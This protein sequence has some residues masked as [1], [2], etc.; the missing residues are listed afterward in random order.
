MIESVEI[1]QPY[2]SNAI[3]LVLS[4]AFIL[5]PII[6]LI[7]AWEVW[8]R[9]INELFIKNIE[10]SQLE[11]RIPKDVFKSPAAM[12]L[13][14]HS[15]Y[16]TSGVNTWVKKY[17]LG[18]LIYWHS[19]EIVSINGNVFFFI[20]TPSRFKDIIEANVYAQYP[21]AEVN[22]VDDYA[23]RMP[24]YDKKKNDWNMFGVEFA[25]NKPDPFPIKTFV[26]YGLDRAIGSLKEEERVDPLTSTLEFMGSLKENEQLWMQILIRPSHLKRYDLPVDLK[27]MKGPKKKGDWIELGKVEIQKIIDKYSNVG[28]DGKQLGKMLNIP[29]GEMNVINAIERNITKFG[30]D[31]GVRA[32]YFGKG[33]AFKGSNIAGMLGMLKQ[34]TSNDLNGFKYGNGTDF[35][36]PWEDPLGFRVDRLKRVMFNAYRLRSYFYAPYERKPFVLSVEELATIFHF[37]GRVAETPSFKRIDS[38]KAEPPA[39]LPL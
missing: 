37:P 2:S 25:L 3:D 12:E 31:C 21:Q 38:K 6:L 22:E 30:F 15:F 5:G 16:Q 34:F 27:K 26:D 1:L 29:K 23:F 36:Y 33:D 39:N 11:I 24:P 32:I 14:I 9:Y 28:E 20:R 7:I 35:D 18:N 13:M 10:W 17:W 8:V 4:F 19:L